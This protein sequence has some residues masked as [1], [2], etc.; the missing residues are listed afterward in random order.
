MPRHFGREF[1]KLE[2]SKTKKERELEQ[3]RERNERKKLE[4]KWEILR[5][6]TMYINEN[7]DARGREKEDRG[8]IKWR[9]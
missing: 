3:R 9:E 5:W 1:E 6:I 2:E 8:E 4:S 7:K